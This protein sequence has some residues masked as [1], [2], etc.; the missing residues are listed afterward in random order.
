MPL[1]VEVR[2]HCAERLL[3]RTYMR[4]IFKKAILAGGMLGLASLSYAQFTTVQIGGGAPG[5]IEPN[6][7]GNYSVVGGG[8]DIWGDSGDDFTYH[9]VN[10]TGDFDVRMRIDSL[11]MA[12]TWTKAGI[13]S[14][15]NDDRF[16]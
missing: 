9:Y 8:N 13:M 11:E 5:S 4:A 3:N 2:L 14:R 1:F 7:P 15:E 6:G 16:S 10:V 12:A